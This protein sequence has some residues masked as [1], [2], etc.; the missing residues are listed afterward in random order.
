MTYRLPPLTTLRLF[1]AAA[2]LMSFK[3]AAEEL[4]LTPSAVSHGI[5]TLE[6][7][8]GVRLFIR[9]NRGLDLTEAGQAYLP[10]V[11][12]A[13]A[14]L[15]RATDAVPGRRPS[16]KLSVSCASTF[17]A[18]WLLPSLPRFQ[19]RHPE[20]QVSMDTRFRQVEF[21]RDGIDVAIR[22]AAGPWD[23]LHA[24]KLEEEWLVPVCTPAM[25]E[26]IS[27]C[28]DLARATLLHN[29]SVS[30]DWAYWFATKGEPEI[31]PARSSRFDTIQ[32]VLDA[33]ISGLGV[34]IGRLPLVQ[35]DL[36]S[37]RLAMVLGPP[38]PSRTAYWMVCARESLARPEVRA[39]RDWLRSELPLSRAG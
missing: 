5:Q 16:G 35:R 27:S 18:R 7:W 19:A 8:L 28:A 12:E 15:A 24:L 30:T 2:R 23:G 17:A 20:I 26:T 9:Y 13:L 25:A 10:Q 32:M 29:V 36:D 39:F 37:G 4:G 1:E 21:P 6:D 33:A 3:Q 38:I 31:E 22:L 11:S 34:G 14:S